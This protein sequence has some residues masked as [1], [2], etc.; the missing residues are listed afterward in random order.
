MATSSHLRSPLESLNTNVLIHILSAT[1]SLSDLHAFI[2]AS[3]IFYQAFLT[4]K[5]TILLAV[6]GVGQ[7]GPVLPDAIML[8]HTIMTRSWG[9]WDDWGEEDPRRLR[10]QRGVKIPTREEW[11]DEK[12]STYRSL[13]TLGSESVT[14]VR[15]TT[16]FLPDEATVICLVRVLRSVE[17][18]VNLYATTRLEYFRRRGLVELPQCT[19]DLTLSERRSLMRAFIRRQI[20]S[21]LLYQRSGI[22]REL[23]EDLFDARTSTLFV[24]WEMEQ[25]SQAD[26][27]I[28]QVAEALRRCEKLDDGGLLTKGR[29]QAATSQYQMDLRTGRRSGGGAVEAIPRP[30]EEYLAT[31]SQNLLALHD[32]MREATRLDQG[33]MERI[34]SFP[35]LFSPADEEVSGNSFLRASHSYRLGRSPR[36]PRGTPALP[37][38]SEPPPTSRLGCPAAWKEAIG[39]WR[40]LGWGKD[41]L[42]GTKP[43]DMQEEEWR[44]LQQ[45][46]KLWRW[47]GFMFFDKDRVEA[48]K[49]A[50]I[51]DAADGW[52]GRYSEEI[53]DQ[54]VRSLP[55]WP[56]GDR[57][58]VGIQ[59]L[60]W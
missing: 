12:V 49:S 32:K 37:A 13:L 29:E 1:E 2:H 46:F 36:Q 59:L 8:S 45:K 11:F 14:V 6:G 48:L 40:A 50:G 5:C 38:T 25:I 33:L 35:S 60:N 31:L 54:L 43:D 47:A 42:P 58:V 28:Y 10:Q 23:G 30:R 9:D 15:R 3:P 18:F 22:A 27:F 39:P 55:V 57:N 52:L 34:L 7:L 19:A 20:V 26:M 16:A 53:R 56:G 21:N 51:L 17:F 41:L 44:D 24:N 4:S